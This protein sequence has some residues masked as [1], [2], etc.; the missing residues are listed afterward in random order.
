MQIASPAVFVVLNLIVLL[1]AYI[2]TVNVYHKLKKGYPITAM[3]KGPRKSIVRRRSVHKV[4]ATTSTTSKRIS[5]WKKLPT[6][7]MRQMK[8]VRDKD[9]KQKQEQG[10]ILKSST[11]NKKKMS[12]EQVKAFHLLDENNRWD[13][14]KQTKSLWRGETLPHVEAGAE[15]YTID[16]LKCVHKL[17]DYGGH[18]E[19]GQVQAARMF[20]ESN[21][22]MPAGP[23]R[24]HK[25]LLSE[26][27]RETLRRA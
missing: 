8:K 1:P 23:Q 26:P 15:Y 27:L 21:L 22:Q 12:D 5:S 16:A 17:D 19:D 11:P 14:Q 13:D 9:L 4:A 6:A 10:D 3:G 7:T 24:F 18:D 20:S 25:V 2:R